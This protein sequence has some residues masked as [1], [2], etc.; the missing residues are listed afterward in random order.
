VN[1]S[2]KIAL[3]GIVTALAT[4][5]MLIAG[6]V[7]VGTY[8]LPAISG[9]LLITIVLELGYRWA[10]MVFFAVSVLSILI[11]TDKEASL[12]FIVFFG[13]YPILKSHIERLK[14]RPVQ[15]ILKLTVFNVAMIAEFFVAMKVLGIPEDSYTVFGVSL[16]WVFLLIGNVIFL[17]YDYALTGLVAMYWERLHP[18]LKKTLHL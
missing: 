5:L 11:G 6:P 13:Y 3:G 9:V 15:W 12:L 17:I 2:G 10:W 8:A 7:S 1:Q 14:Q 18:V 16:P 4:V